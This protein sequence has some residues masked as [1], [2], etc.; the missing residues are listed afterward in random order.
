MILDELLPEKG[1]KDLIY[2]YSCGVKYRYLE[3]IIKCH[4][5][6]LVETA[7]NN[8]HQLI[9]ENLTDYF[10]RV[11]SRGDMNIQEKT[12]NI[13]I[14]LRHVSRLLSNKKDIGLRMLFNSNKLT[15]TDGLYTA[16]GNTIK[17]IEK[18]TGL[19]ISNIYY[20]NK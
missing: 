2:E 7:E 13:K 12:L 6:I 3:K 10:F 8:N 11:L 1:L 19:F 15:K 18:K 9:Y 5:K 4:F 17:D 16:I 20:A 14:F